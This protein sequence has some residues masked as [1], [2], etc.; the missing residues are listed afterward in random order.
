MPFTILRKTRVQWPGSEFHEMYVLQLSPHKVVQAE[1]QCGCL[2]ECFNINGH[3]ISIGCAS[4]RK[5]MNGPFSPTV[6][7]KFRDHG[8]PCRI[9]EQV[10]LRGKGNALKQSAEPLRH[11]VII[12]ASPVGHTGNLKFNYRTPALLA[13][14]LDPVPFPCWLLLPVPPPPPPCCGC[15]YALELLANAVP[16]RLILPI[17][18]TMLLP[19]ASTAPRGDVS[20]GPSGAV[21]WTRNNLMAVPFH[22]PTVPLTTCISLVKT[23]LQSNDSYHPRDKGDHSNE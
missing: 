2:I 5:N 10:K 6:N 12:K 3:G 11:L 14:G 22:T 15:V 16:R 18:E 1:E 13:D 20:D 4:K 17:R 7:F 19:T 8:R 21:S 9:L 23:K